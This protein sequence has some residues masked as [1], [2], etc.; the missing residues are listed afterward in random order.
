MT[1]ASQDQALTEE[2]ARP[3]SGKSQAAMLATLR[4]IYPWVFL[5][6]M[7]VFFTVAS[8]AANGVNFLTPRALQGIA[9]YAT[10]ILLLGLGETLIIISAG[11]DLSVAWT[12]GFSSVIAADIMKYLY[13][14]GYGPIETI[15]LG[16]LGG[17]FVAVFPGLLNGVLVTRW[18]VPSFISTLAVGFVIE[19]VALLRSH[20]Y[21][22]ADQ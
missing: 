15:G 22:I 2:V 20:G 7:M 8:Q 12:L 18:N 17:I 9:V 6:T 19:G 16:I 3:S 13:G 4:K 5:I 1:V 11:I 10:Q 21:P 14:S